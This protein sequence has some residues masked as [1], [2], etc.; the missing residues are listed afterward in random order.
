M[1]TKFLFPIILLALANLYGCKNASTVKVE[2]AIDSTRAFLDNWEAKNREGL[3][4][5][6]DRKTFTDQWNL[7]VKKNKA[8]GLIRAFLSKEQIKE[9]EI[10]Y[11]DAK[12]LNNKM[13]MQ[14]MQNNFTSRMSNSVSQDEELDQFNIDF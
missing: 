13:M 7:R 10:I 3:L 8:Q 5:P 6:E 12:T 9:V 2:V 1:K 4:T 14:A 11:K